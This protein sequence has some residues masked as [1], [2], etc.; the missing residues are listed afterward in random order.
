[1]KIRIPAVFCILSLLLTFSG[2]QE[3]QVRLTRQDLVPR[4][5]ELEQAWEKARSSEQ[6]RARA[7]PFINQGVT[8]FFSGQFSSLS[9]SLGRAIYALQHS[10]EPSPEVTYAYGLGIRLPRIIDLNDSDEIV[11]KT[12][13]LYKLPDQVKPLRFAWEIR[14]GNNI[15]AASHTPAS[16]NL[17]LKV[18]CK[19]LTE[20]DYQVRVR[21][22]LQGQLIREWQEPVS[23]LPDV[24][25]RIEALEAKIA[26]YAAKVNPIE[27][28]SV[29]MWITVL[30]AAMEGN[31][32]E[33][34]YPLGELLRKA[35][36][37]VKEWQAN[38]AF[39]KPEPGDY[40][41]ATPYNQRT[42]YFRLYL[43]NK[44]QN[45][46]PLPLIVALH[47]AG[48]NEH[49]FFEGYGLG[50]VLKEAEKRG[51]AVIAPRSSGASIDHVWG[52]LEAAKIL[53]PVDMKQ[54]YLVGHSMGGAQTFMA[55]SQKPE[56]FAG[57]AVYAGAGAPSDSFKQGFLKKPVFL[58]VGEQE[59]P[60]IKNNV[61][62]VNEQIKTMGLEKMEFKV[63]PACEH[64]M[65]V[66]ESLADSFD[67][68]Q[69]NRV[70]ETESEK[71]K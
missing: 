65:I 3:Q 32:P 27:W 69:A 15:C 2:S 67:Y 1:M 37:A 70:K 55:A 10:E 16:A 8:A 21:I 19:N 38:R 58:S 62:R 11:L 57:I 47:G 39:W 44:V 36:T 61:M 9:Q 53:L 48:G 46:H 43:P 33:S 59:I 50:Q 64:L 4:L 45:G 35:E 60:M 66:R 52:A 28:N 7:V 20:G 25:S 42:V 71:T 18:G 24:K 54:V 6:A 23:I 22:Q 68:L 5:M 56:L 41:I 30:K 49:M 14:G 34:Q 13:A 12:M 40:W 31:A 29:Q 51:W 63:Y 26:P 17:S